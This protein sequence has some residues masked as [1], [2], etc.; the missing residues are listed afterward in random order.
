MLSTGRN[1]SFGASEK[2]DR[3]IDL[4]RDAHTAGTDD[5][6]SIIS[7]IIVLKSTNLSRSSG[8]AFGGSPN[9]VSK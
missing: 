7:E 3:I 1:Q 2:G 5:R 8:M 4:A 9:S 6:N